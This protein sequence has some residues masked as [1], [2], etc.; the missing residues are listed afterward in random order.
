LR[1]RS[2]LRS[3]LSPLGE[4]PSPRGLASKSF[5]QNRIGRV[6][7]QLDDRS[8]AEAGSFE[9]HVAVALHRP[10]IVLFEQERTDRPRDDGLF[11]KIP[12]TPVRR[13]ISPQKRSSGLMKLIFTSGILREAHDGRHVDR[14]FVP[15]CASLGT[16]ARNQDSCGRG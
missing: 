5:R 1:A 7:R 16:F 10:Y 8:V 14:C 13:L 6:T 15:Q 3:R 9:L 11:G 2:R 12:T 4:Q